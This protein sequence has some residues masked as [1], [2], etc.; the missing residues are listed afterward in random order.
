[1]I[2][3]ECLAVLI[4]YLLYRK[5][6]EAQLWLCL[7]N[8]GLK[9]F[10]LDILGFVTATLI[11]FRCWFCILLF[12]HVFFT[13]YLFLINLV[14]CI[15][16]GAKL[17]FALVMKYCVFNHLNKKLWNTLEPL[18]SHFRFQCF[19]PLRSHGCTLQQRSW[20]LKQIKFNF[21]HISW[22]YLFV[23]ILSFYVKHSKLF[24]SILSVYVIKR[25]SRI[26][27]SR[28]GQLKVNVWLLFGSKIYES[29]QVFKPTKIFNFQWRKY[30]IE[31]RFFFVSDQNFIHVFKWLKLACRAVLVNLFKCWIL[32]EKFEVA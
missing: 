11:L 8:F 14:V 25:F 6:Y 16:S 29:C 32:F 21:S 10:C 24:G 19:V 9:S 18:A 4:F 13:A 22:N 3:L 23:V 27:S 12:G 1:M 17:S 7:K 28:S 2:I 20:I 15:A 26:L 30:S 31:K 5:W